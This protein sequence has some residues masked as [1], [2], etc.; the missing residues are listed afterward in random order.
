MNI[1]LPTQLEEYVNEKV[2]SGRYASASEVI[3]EALRLMQREDDIIAANLEDIR[4]NVAAG[5]LDA[6]HGRTTDGRTVIAKLRA[7]NDQKS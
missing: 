5:K 3:R 2:T 1:S 7:E 6:R 4:R